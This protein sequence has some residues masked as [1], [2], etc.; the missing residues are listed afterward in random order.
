MKIYL[1]GPMRGYPN[2]NFPAFEKA[3]AFL[4]AKGHT[5]FSPAER[6]KI[7]HG[8]VDISADNPTGDEA[9]AKAKFGFN[10]RDALADDTAWICKEA[11]GIAMLPGWRQSKGAVAEEALA[12]ALGLGVMFLE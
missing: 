3:A 5:V 10:L 11:D 6:D 1:A 8:G 12:E 4:R 7:R 2:F 9:V